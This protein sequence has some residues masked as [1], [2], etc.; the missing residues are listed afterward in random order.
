MLRQHLAAL[1]KQRVGLG[2]LVFQQPGLGRLD[3]LIELMGVAE[4]GDGT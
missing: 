2:A 1:A 4:A 3:D